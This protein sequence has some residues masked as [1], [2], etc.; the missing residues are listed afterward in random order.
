MIA[1]AI[2]K[3]VFVSHILLLIFVFALLLKN[4]LGKPVADFLGKHSVILGLLIILSAIVGSLLY[5]NVLGFD[6]CVLCWWQ[7][8]FIYPQA[9]IFLVAIIIKDKKVFS[10]IVPFSVVV[11]LIALYHSYLQI[12]GTSIIPCDALGVSCSKVLVRDFG[13]ITIPVMSLTVALYTLVLAW[14]HKLYEK[15]NSHA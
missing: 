11:L 8:I 15:N 4:S 5:S 14:A 9:F 7:R 2:P 3:L 10:Y 6:P 13:Y 12:G 1:S